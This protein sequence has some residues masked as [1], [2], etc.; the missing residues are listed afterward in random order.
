MFWLVLLS[1]FVNFLI[2]I[3]R[4]LQGLSSCA[5][6]VSVQDLLPK[7]RSL[8]EF[9]GLLLTIIFIWQKTS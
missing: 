6:A 5:S 9:A 8:D 1:W 7:S 3:K 2:M 4:I